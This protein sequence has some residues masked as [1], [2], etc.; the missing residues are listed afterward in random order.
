MNIDANHGGCVRFHSSTAARRIRVKG[1]EASMGWQPSD[2]E[3][4]VTDH[5]LNQA[6]VRQLPK[7]LAGRATAMIPLGL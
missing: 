4:A 7:S 5:F 6:L 3:S 1:S 2:Y